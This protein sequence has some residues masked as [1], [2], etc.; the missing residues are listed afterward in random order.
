MD[1]EN[2]ISQ[3]TP[4]Q[5]I[6][7]GSR[8]SE[9]LAWH[10][11][12]AVLEVPQAARERIVVTG[13]GAVSAWG[14]S[15]SSLWSGLRSNRTGIGT[16]RRFDTR[17][18]RT[19]VVGEVPEADAGIHAGLDRWQ[20]YSRADRFAVA[21]AVEACRQAG[22]ITSPE[23]SPPGLGADAGVFFG[24]STG[25]MAEGEEYFRALL[26]DGPGSARLSLLAPH[27][28]NCPGD[29]VARLL[30][31]RGPVRSF[32][33]ACA[34]GALAIGAALDAL[35]RGEVQVAIAGGA[36][37]LCQLTYAGFN[38]L[39]AV[40]SRPC[41]PFRRE[42]AGLSLGEGAGILIL[43]PLERARSRGARPLAEILGAGGSCDAHH[44]TA[45]H[46]RGVGAARAIQRAL[47]NAAIDA[48]AIDFI[49]AHG[50][51]TPRNDVAEWQAIRKVFG[52][53]AA[54]IPVTS[55]KGSVG[56]LL[57]SSGAI[58]AVATVQCLLAGEVHP[59]PG[60]GSLDEACGVDLVHSRP[61]PLPTAAP[62]EAAVA[63]STSFGFGGANA[64][65]VLGG[66]GAPR[67]S[68]SSEG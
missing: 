7:P 2:D 10:I 50:T 24:G 36:D 57:G 17:G 30:G 67:D 66:I 3:H 22:W 37:S 26:D 45:P 25:G 15:A 18:H 12:A 8:K 56:H 53:R 20:H 34:S 31:V 48:N 54:S 14:W 4:G 39:R 28:L 46:P 61:R 13:L 41:R 43:E 16:S 42:R 65:L 5:R 64:A 49:N 11:L 35:R 68:G 52:A 62:G 1:G 23:T 60:D 58:E 32:T 63:V 55:T 47:Q 19:R 21:A 33:S 59:T 6:C 38:S 40:D 29:E 51:A 9:S 44:M 27:Q